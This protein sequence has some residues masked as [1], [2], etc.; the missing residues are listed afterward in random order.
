MAAS[1]AP[2]LTPEKQ[3]SKFEISNT[4]SKLPKKR[5]SNNRL[6]AVSKR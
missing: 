6:V 5:K 4:T 2:Y 1:L 3:D